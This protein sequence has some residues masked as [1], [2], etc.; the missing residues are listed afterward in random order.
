[1][2]SMPVPPPPGKCG[3]E[4]SLPA[5]KWYRRDPGKTVAIAMRH[6][7]TLVEIL[8][9]VAIVGLLSAI[10]APRL[11]DAL[12]RVTVTNA[13]H[14]LVAAHTRARLTAT[15]ESRVT[16][17]TL[18]AD[19]LSVRVIDGVDTLPLWQEPGPAATGVTLAGP[20][21]P[22]VFVPTGLTHGLANGTWTLTR[23]A[24][25]RSV[26]ISRA[27]RVRIQ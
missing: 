11:A 20:S 27:G 1:M 23:G 3:G 22:V 5:C 9:V 8:L 13:A 25:T 18:R 16:L 26:I 21:H 17:L 4:A 24:A 2:A 7:F 15:V 14:R 6:G 10:G 19:T 12:R